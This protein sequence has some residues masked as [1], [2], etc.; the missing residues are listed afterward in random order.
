MKINTGRG[1]RL[2]AQW[3]A[4]NPSNF[5][6]NSERHQFLNH[7][8]INTDTCGVVKYSKRWSR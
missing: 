4:V 5:L 8:G 2:F 3:S 6:I 1:D 7:Q